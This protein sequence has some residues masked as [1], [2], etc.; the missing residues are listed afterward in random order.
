MDGSCRRCIIDNTSVV[1]AYGSGSD[2]VMAPEM[3]AFG[4]MFGMK[5]VAHHINDADRKAKAERNFRYIENNFLAGRTF[6][7]WQDLNRRAI[8][9]CDTVANIKPKRSLGRMSPQKD[10]G[11]SITGWK[12]KPTTRPT[13]FMMTTKFFSILVL[14]VEHQRRLA[15]PLNTVQLEYLKALNVDPN[16]FISP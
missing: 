7:G 2:A 16:T 12:D 14:K 4:R 3:E 15:R 13:S 6:T 9:W 5:F 1:I 8:K 10:T 11:N